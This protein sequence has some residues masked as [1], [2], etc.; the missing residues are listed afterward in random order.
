MGPA[1]KQYG[2][3]SPVTGDLLDRLRWIL[4]NHPSIHDVRRTIRKLLCN[5]S[6]S[7]PTV[8]RALNTSDRSLQR[9]LA[10]LGTSYSREL[11]QV[12]RETAISLFKDDSLEIA[13]VAALLGYTDAGSFTRAF[14]RWAGIPPR[15]S[16]PPCQ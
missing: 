16:I 3:T 12:R 9:Q 4:A 11:D 8:A 14:T 1:D 7:L 6:P 10:M 5:G 13:N 15:E 2:F